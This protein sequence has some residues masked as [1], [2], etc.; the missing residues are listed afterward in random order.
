MKGRDE[1]MAVKRGIINSVILPTLSYSTS[2]T[3]TL[4][5]AQQSRIRAVEMSYVR[6]ACGVSRLNRESNGDTYGRFSMSKT[7]LGMDCGVVEW[8]KRN[9]L[10]WYGHVMKRN[11]CI[12]KKG[13]I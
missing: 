9:T 8:V 13:T 12:Y 3:W 2:E 11:E 5:E 10:R 7:A 6:G 1:S 4:N